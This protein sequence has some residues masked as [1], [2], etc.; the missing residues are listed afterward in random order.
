MNLIYELNKDCIGFK[1]YININWNEIENSYLS[2]NNSKLTI[3]RK[4]L[5]K[6]LLDFKLEIFYKDFLIRRIFESTL[7]NTSEVI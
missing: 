6:G 2:N 1:E 4:D 7:I 5:K 3:P